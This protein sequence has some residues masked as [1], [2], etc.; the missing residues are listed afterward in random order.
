[1]AVK[2]PFLKHVDRVDVIYLLA[3]ADGP[4]GSGSGEG[5][6]VGFIVKKNQ[7]ELVKAL[8]IYTN[9]IEDLGLVV[10]Q[11]YDFN[12]LA[13]ICDDA[14]EHRLSEQF[15]P[16][17][18]DFTPDN[19]F[20][21]CVSNRRGDILSFQA[22]RLDYL[23]GISLK[24]HWAAQQR[25]IYCDPY[26]DQEPELGVNHAY[27]T[28]KITGRVVYHGEMWLHP[29][30]RGGRKLGG[31][32]CRIGQLL[33]FLKWD[34]DYIYCFISDVLHHKGFTAAQGYQ[35][36]EPFGTDWVR[37]PSHIPTDDYLCW[38]QPHNLV[39]L[40]WATIRSA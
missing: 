12:Y 25:R 37:P 27:A 26:P 3:G 15:S 14:H 1:M 19:S 20:W 7:M 11:E 17:Y 10:T 40:A 4:K 30:L 23:A 22:A 39:R 2:Q 13:D 5:K 9:L 32:I 35:N 18:F 16:R 24:Q 36:C 8:G 31:P 6:T 28:E 21:V 34:F 38:N 29:D 33:A